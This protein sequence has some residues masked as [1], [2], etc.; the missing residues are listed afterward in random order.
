MRPPRPYVADGI[1]RWESGVQT[2]WDKSQRSRLSYAELDVV[3]ELDIGDPDEFG[4]PH[5][6]LSRV[7]PNLP[8]FGGCCGTDHRHVERVSSHLHKLDPSG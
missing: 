3:E 4:L 2:G 8:V 6:E 5:V 1:C 7:M